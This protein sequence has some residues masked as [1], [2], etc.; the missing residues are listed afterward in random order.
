MRK[1][2]CAVIFLTVAL[3]AGCTVPKIVHEQLNVNS[4]ELLAVNHKL[5]SQC[6]LLVTTTLTPSTWWSIVAPVR[7][8][9]STVE[10]KHSDIFE[11]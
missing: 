4:A 11:D 6:T 7:K 3:L 9:T 8:V 1:I 5:T 2:L 10:C